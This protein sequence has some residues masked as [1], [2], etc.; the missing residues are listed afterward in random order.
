VLDLRRHIP[1]SEPVG[2]VLKAVHQNR[3]DQLAGPILFR[4]L[5]EPCAEVVNS[6]AD[7]IEQG[8]GV[9]GH[10]GFPGQGDESLHRDGLGGHQIFIIEENKRELCQPLGLLLVPEK[11]VEPLD[12]GILARVHRA[13]AVENESDLGVTL[14][15]GKTISLGVGHPQGD[16]L[17]SP[18]LLLMVQ[19]GVPSIIGQPLYYK[20]H[21]LW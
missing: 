15:H 16:S 11:P 9:P 17:K 14:V 21:Q 3:H 19:S 1:P 20:L 18:G 4:D 13:G 10:V 6:P 5:P 12:G 7:G 8:R 2:G